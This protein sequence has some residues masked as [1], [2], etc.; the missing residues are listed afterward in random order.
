LVAAKGRAVLLTQGI[1]FSTQ[2]FQAAAV[3]F[4]TDALLA[5]EIA[6]SFV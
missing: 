5:A 2:D 4:S 6:A 3:S 1:L